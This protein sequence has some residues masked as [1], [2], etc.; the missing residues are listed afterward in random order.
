MWQVPAQLAPLTLGRDGRVIP[1]VN[2][3]VLS[4]DSRP[5]PGF[6]PWPS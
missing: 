5:Q 1:F 2:T 3:H 6:V 4:P